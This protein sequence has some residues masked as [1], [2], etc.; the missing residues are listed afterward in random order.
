MVNLRILKRNLTI[1]EEL[2][3]FSFHLEALF[4]KQCLLLIKLGRIS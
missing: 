3:D 1:L 4:P 2:V